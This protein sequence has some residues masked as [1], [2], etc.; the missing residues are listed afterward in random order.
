MASFSFPSLDHNNYR[1]SR[2]LGG[3]ALADLGPYAAAI[4]RFLFKSKPKKV[5]CKIIEKDVNTGVDIAFS[6]MAIYSDSRSILGYFGFNSEYQNFIKCT[7]SDI[8]IYLNRFI[9]L[10][11]NIDAIIE[12]TKQGDENEYLKRSD[13][14]KNFLLS[15]EKAIK[16]SHFESFYQDILDDA[17]FRNSM[18][19]STIK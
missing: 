2:E 12:V 10:P 16:H 3:G 13:A 1:Y 11:N 6:V 8:S 19:I 15:I 4:G 5:I 7:G 9:S 17:I 14:F 18:E